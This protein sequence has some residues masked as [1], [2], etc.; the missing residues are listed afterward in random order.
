MIYLNLLYIAIIVVCIVDISGF[1]DSVKRLISRILTKGKIIKTDFRIKPF[2][3]SLCTTFWTGLIYILATG[4]F[5][6][7]VLAYVLILAVFTPV[8][9]EIII[10]LKD[11]IIKIVNVIYEHFID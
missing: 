7:L 9:K 1:I 6:L 3:C 5:S 11:I 10:L 4:Q 8:I 2:D